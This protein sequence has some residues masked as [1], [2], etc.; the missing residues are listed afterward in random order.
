MIKIYAQ[1][2][3]DIDALRADRQKTVDPQVEATVTEILAQVRDKGDAAIREFTARFDRAEIKDFQVKEAEI[4]RA[5]RKVSPDFLAVLEQAAVQIRDYHRYQLRDDVASEKENG[6]VLGQRFTPI[7]K[8]GIYVPGGTAAYPSSVLMNAIP[9]VLAGCRQIVMVTP[10]RPDGTIGADILAAA[11]IAGITDIYKL[12]G[13]QAIA[14]LAYGTE[15]V[16]KVDKIVGPGNIF[17]ATAKKQVFGQV[18]IDMFAGPS[19]ILVIADQTANPAYLAADMLSQA[20][21]DVLASA[22]LIC[23]SQDMAERVAAELT[24]QLEQL[25]RRQIAAKSLDNQGAI[26]IAESLDAAVG[27]ANLLAPE[28]LELAVEAPFD[29][30]PKITN[31]GS[32]FLGPYTPEPLGDYWAGPNHVLPTLGSARFF[33]PLSVDDFIKRSSY[34]YYTKEALTAAADAVATFAEREGLGAHAQSIRIR[35]E[36]QS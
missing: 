18:A 4:E 17:V 14:A 27:F 28:H 24:R 31:A 22:M 16:P 36:E 12:G 5:W 10:P 3:I 6:I 29:W 19:E 7:E 1:K 21:H 9:A 32:I 8:V 20:E 34:I 30:L 26:I 15:S 2:Q 13:A 25:P 23:L 11:R 35:M 33:G